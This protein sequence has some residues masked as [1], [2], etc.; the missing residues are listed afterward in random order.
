[1]AW[2]IRMMP[3]SAPCAGTCT[4]LLM[5]VCMSLRCIAM[6]SSTS[7]I[8]SRSSRG[9]NS[10]SVGGSEG[11]GASAGD[12]V[13]FRHSSAKVDPKA[14]QPTGNPA[15]CVR[16]PSL[17][18]MCS[19]SSSSP[20][21]LL[22]VAECR[23]WAGDGCEPTNKD[24]TPQVR[25]GG[26]WPEP[27]RG[28]SRLS[29]DGGFTWGSLVHNVTGMGAIDMQT[30]FLPRLNKVM[31]A[32]N[33]HNPRHIDHQHV[34]WYRLGSLA[35]LTATET[36]VAETSAAVVWEPPVSVQSRLVAPAGHESAWWGACPGPG[37]ASVLQ[38]EKGP[39][40]GR[41]I[42]AVY[43][44]GIKGNSDW[45]PMDCRNPN[46][47]SADGD[48]AASYCNQQACII[49]LFAPTKSAS[50]MRANA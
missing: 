10:A 18:R 22:A 28:C 33:R 5:F 6:P 34:L 45:D 23:Y 27:S 13:V 36:R 38:N 8:I 21:T 46:F 37:R 30:V 35:T 15:T 4:W 31:L 41:I 48:W 25:V 24:Q 17:V 50:D 47:T 9:R 43:Q 14:P 19:G 7:L 42:L 2:H 16:N 32:F 20:A 3:Y 44:E 40:V 12:V 49:Y 11:E 1:M 39:H 29:T 26:P